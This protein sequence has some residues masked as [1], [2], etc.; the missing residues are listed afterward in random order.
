MMLV[1]RRGIGD[2]STTAGYW[3]TFFGGSESVLTGGGSGEAPGT[4]CPDGL[5][6]DVVDGVL[7]PC[8][9]AGALAPGW[10]AR[11]SSLVI[12]LGVG[13][14]ALAMLRGGRR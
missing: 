12:G 5:P 4:M 9:A 10:F 8:G 7:Q 11:N 14:F 13:I 2:T 6:H 3:S 1:R